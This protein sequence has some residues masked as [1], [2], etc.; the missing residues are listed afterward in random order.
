M[1][2]IFEWHERIGADLLRSWGMSNMAVLVARH[3]HN[4]GGARTAERSA[5]HL[6]SAIDLLSHWLT[7]LK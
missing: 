7:I 4:L 3:H 1:D 6:H 5:A 2:R